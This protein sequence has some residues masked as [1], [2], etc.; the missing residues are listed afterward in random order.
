MNPTTCPL[1]V[2]HHPQE[3][4]RDSLVYVIDASNK[5]LPG[6]IRVILTRHVKEMM[7]LSDSERHHVMRGVF[8]IESA[9][10]CV[11]HPEKVNLAEFGTLVPHVH[12]HII[13]RF[14]DDAYFPESTWSQKVRQTPESVLAARRLD[15]KALVQQL[16]QI[17]SKEFGD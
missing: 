10:R 16:P 13:A 9:M 4:W 15:A 1:C 11:M 5:D 14:R 7:D 8:C 3:I 6:Y 17:L 12:W 2:F